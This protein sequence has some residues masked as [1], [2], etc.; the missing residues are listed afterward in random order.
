MVLILYNLEG[1]CEDPPDV[2]HGCEC[3]FCCAVFK[4]TLCMQKC[5]H[6][7]DNLVL[8]RA[9]KIPV[10]QLLRRPEL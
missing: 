5:C 8:V 10:T 7:C 4:I 9:K 3:N 2:C 1:D 6:A